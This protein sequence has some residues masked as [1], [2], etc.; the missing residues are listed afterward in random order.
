[1]FEEPK[2]K[3]KAFKI[4][5][6]VR[7]PRVM[8]SKFN[9][10]KIKRMKTKNMASPQ[11]IEKMKTMSWKNRGSMIH[12]VKRK[13]TII[14]AVILNKERSFSAYAT[15]LNTKEPFYGYE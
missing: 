11:K 14:K 1:M 15:I 9:S 12:P 8:N 6:K 5:T 3:K 13:S 4:L 7:Q 2:D 10:T